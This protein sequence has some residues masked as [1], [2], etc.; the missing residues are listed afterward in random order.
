[1]E[2]TSDVFLVAADLEVY[3]PNVLYYGKNASAGPINFDVDNTYKGSANLVSR[4]RQD[5]D[6]A[7]I[8]SGVDFTFCLIPNQTFSIIRR[9]TYYED[10]TL[11]ADNTTNPNTGTPNVWRGLP[12]V[13][14]SVRSAAPDF[15]AYDDD[16]LITFK[17]IG[18]Y[19]VSCNITL[20]SGT[21][22]GERLIVELRNTDGSNAGVGA[23]FR[24]TLDRFGT[25]PIVVPVHGFYYNEV[26]NTQ[27]RLSYFF[28]AQQQFGKLKLL[29]RRI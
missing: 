24:D 7:I 3:K 15:L 25:D 14:T 4:Y 8:P 10:R 6:L 17:T 20:L 16:G 27:L 9:E 18:T 28:S 13:S 5:P 2:F 29:A 26:E 19:E 11:Y 21:S 23:F 22:T 1:V 12:I